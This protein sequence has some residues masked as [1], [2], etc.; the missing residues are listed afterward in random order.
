MVH[1]IKTIIAATALFFLTGMVVAK[2]A[3]K[4]SPWSYK[5]YVL[6]EA[7]D[8]MHGGLKTGTTAT[9]AGRLT[10]TFDTE[11]AN[12]WCGGKIALGV[13][14][15]GQLHNPNLYLAAY[16]TP[17]GY[18]GVSEIVINDLAYQH[19]FNRLLMVRAGIMDMDD[20]FNENEIANVML[21]SAFTNTIAMSSNAQLP[22][23]P[24][25]G[26]GAMGR[27]GNKKFAFLLGVFQ[28]N[29]DHQDSVF[30]NGQLIIGEANMY[31]SRRNQD[32][33][34][35]IFKFGGWN[36]Q[37]RYSY[38]GTS[39]QGLYGIFGITWRTSKGRNLGGSVEFGLNPKKRNTVTDSVSWCITIGGLFLNRPNDSLNFGAGRAWPKGQPH[40]ELFHELGYTIQFNKCWA[41]TPDLQYFVHPGGVYRNAWVG[42]VRL[43]YI[44]SSK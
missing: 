32:N 22:T 3:P 7:I 17:S 18:A 4:P 25:P 40:S 11:K 31:V 37:Q 12:W 23:Y 21:N 14:G 29:P 8:N 38:V 19:T 24:Y 28:G 2:P 16:Q 36:Y 26:F 5:G 35:Y 41:L 30:H 9:L 27:F 43:Q 15:I 42:V 39:D 33:I 13:L 1:I 6:G 44:F 20:W 10:A 34:Q